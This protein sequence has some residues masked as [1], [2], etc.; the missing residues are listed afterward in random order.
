MTSFRGAMAKLGAGVENELG[1]LAAHHSDKRMWSGRHAVVMW[2]GRRAEFLGVK[3]AARTAAPSFQ[4]CFACVHM[5]VLY[6]CVYI[7]VCVY[8]CRHDM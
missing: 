7:C 3:L 8:V 4:T 1:G 6:A 2:T 5:Y